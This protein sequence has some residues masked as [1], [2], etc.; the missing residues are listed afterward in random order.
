M[1]VA[2]SLKILVFAGSKIYQLRGGVI[3]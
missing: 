3:S 2:I 1:T